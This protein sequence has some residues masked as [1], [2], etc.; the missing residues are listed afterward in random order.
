MTFKS[1]IIIFSAIT[2]YL[3]FTWFGFGS[4]HPCEILLIRQKDHHMRLAERRHQE[5]LQ[6]LRETAGKALP[7][8]DYE[9]FVRDM[10]EYSTS[11]ARGESLHTSVVKELR[12]KFDD[13]APAQCA[14]LAVTWRPPAAN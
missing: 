5:D 9:R 4:P 1:L 7:A 6:S 14:W 11:S 12:Q 10:E 8:T 3:T 13:M 2:G